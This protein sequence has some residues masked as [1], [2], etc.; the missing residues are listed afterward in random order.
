MMRASVI[1]PTFGQRPEYLRD[2][3]ECVQKQKFPASSYEILVIDN[4]PDSSARAIVDKANRTGASGPLHQ[5][6]EHGP[7][8][9]PPCRS[10]RRIGRGHCLCR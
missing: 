5:R 3:V 6:E 10:D 4:S 8:L 1:I 7:A 2:T 9:C